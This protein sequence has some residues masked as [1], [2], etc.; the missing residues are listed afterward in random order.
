MW[1]LS[2]D[3]IRWKIPNSQDSRGIL[4]YKKVPDTPPTHTHT[5]AFQ[6]VHDKSLFSQLDEQEVTFPCCAGF[7]WCVA[8]P[9]VIT[10][11][12]SWA[13]QG[14]VSTSVWDASLVT[15]DTDTLVTSHIATPSPNK[16]HKSADRARRDGFLLTHVR[17]AG[18]PLVSILSWSGHTRT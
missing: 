3:P 5:S 12:A 13:L 2:T 18:R 1:P 15:A 14:L 8:T 17:R 6:F 10:R 7:V 16:E 9:D 4:D 11:P